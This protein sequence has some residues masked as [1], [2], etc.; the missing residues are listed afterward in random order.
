MIGKRSLFAATLLLPALACSAGEGTVAFTTWGEEYIEGKIP[1]TDLVD[2]WE[3]RYTKFLVVLRGITVADAAGTKGATMTGSRL[4]DMTKP[5]KKTVFSATLAAR[6]WEEVSYQI[7][8]ADAQTDA[9]GASEADK[10]LM[11]KDGLSVY[12]DATATKGMVTKRFTWGFKTATL[13]DRCKGDVGGKEI[14]GVLPTAGGTDTAELTI[15]GDHFFYDD[16][17]S[18]DAK[19]RFDA[20]AEADAN[21]DG[22]VTLEELAQVKLASIDASKGPYGTGSASGVVTLADFVTALSRTVGHFRGEG[23][24]FSKPL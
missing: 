20:I 13:Y 4:F 1:A 12:V 8:P 2:G 9:S 16:L 18:P 19:R 23:E 6:P 11:L 10:Q 24:C 21:M 3:I 22:A 7:A 17:A 5:G 14:D 15:H